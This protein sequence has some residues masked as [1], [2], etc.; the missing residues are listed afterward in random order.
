VRQSK[1][2]EYALSDS[3]ESNGSQ[4]IEEERLEPREAAALLTET[5]DKTLRELELDSMKLCL[6]GGF[7]LPVGFGVLWWSVRHQHPYQGPTTGDIGLFYLLL[8]IVDVGAVVVYRRSNRGVGGARQRTRRYLGAIGAV[9]LV[10]TF[11]VMGALDHAHVT[12]TVVY[13]I[14]PATVPL[15]VGG[16]I[17]AT[18]AALRDDWTLFWGALAISLVAAGAAFGGPAGAWLIS[19]AG[20]GAV[21]FI[22]AG[23]KLYQR[24]AQ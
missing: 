22:C 2:S 10:A 9:G 23:I 17:G 15:V 6:L 11:V 4:S 5:K 3:N 18:S 20:G 13:G 21:L 7:L 19:G 12:N 1:G 16:I 24:H 14:Y 8:L